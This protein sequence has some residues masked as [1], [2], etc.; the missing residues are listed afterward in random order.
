MKRSE[1]RNLARVIGFILMCIYLLVLFYLVF[2]SEMFGRHAVHINEYNLVPFKTIGNFIKYHE[3]V[4]TASFLANII[5]NVV[6][7]MP[8]GIILPIILRTKKHKYYI[9][10]VF[11]WAFLLS[12]TIEIVQYLMAVGAFDVDDLILNTSG[13]VI[14]YIIYLVIRV[15]YNRAFSRRGKYER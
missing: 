3:S 12:L 11:F 9:Q 4:S 15:E 14:G 8:F 6:A 1:A 13:A 7:F 10:W 2:F 5:G